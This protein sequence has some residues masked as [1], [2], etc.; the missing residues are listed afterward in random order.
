MIVKIKR[1][2]RALEVFQ[3]E[4]FCLSERKDFHENLI[5][6]TVF[7]DSGKKISKR[8]HVGRFVRSLFVKKQIQ[9]PEEE[10]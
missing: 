8:T 10:G 9:V 4:K 2:D 7:S 1:I 6:V 3:T 5:S